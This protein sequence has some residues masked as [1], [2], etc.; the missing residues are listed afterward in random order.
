MIAMHDSYP[1]FEENYCFLI[2]SALFSAA[3]IISR[4]QDP[5]R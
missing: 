5:Y 1:S 4:S 3:S 2:A